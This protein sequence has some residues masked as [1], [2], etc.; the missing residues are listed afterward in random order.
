MWD[1]SIMLFKFFSLLATAILIGGAFSF[2]LVGQALPSTRKTLQAYIGLGAVSGMLAAV[3]FFLSQIG[4]INQ[5]GLGGMFDFQL[6][7][8]LW[9]S[10]L[11][12]TTGLRL[13]GFALGA[14]IVTALFRLNRIFLASGLSI[15]VLLLVASFVYIGHIS[16]LGLALQ[17]TLALHVLAIGLWIGSLYPLLYACQTT[18]IKALQNLM[19]RFGEL[20][21]Y[22]VLLLLLSG[23]YLLSQLLQSL[24]ELFTTSYGLSLL[25][26][27]MGV[28]ALLLL[29]EANKFRLVPALVQ[30]SGVKALK[31][32]IMSE[33]G[34]A[35]IVLGLTAFLT[36][37]V[38]P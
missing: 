23:I 7:G 25:A 28:A 11:G 5:T 19:K 30:H 21:V 2:W 9:Q 6:I 26:K 36:T 31:R 8:I 27:L 38:G 4:A 17:I 12:Y 20:A 37:S 35:L 32:S 22:I 10:G 33:M 13:L 15:T 16:T 18:D 24:T 14:V 34:L 29:G 1:V 3:L